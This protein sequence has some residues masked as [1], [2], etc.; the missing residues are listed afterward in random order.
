MKLD[1]SLRI[2]KLFEKPV[3]VI[4]VQIIES[5]KIPEDKFLL[6]DLNY[7][8]KNNYSGY[9]NSIVLLAGYPYDI[10][11]NK[12]RHISVGKI[13]QIYNN[14]EFQHELHTE[15]GSSGSPLC[16]LS[17][18]YVIGIHKKGSKMRKINYGTFIGYFLD[19]LEEG[20]DDMDIDKDYELIE[21]NPFQIL[22]ITEEE[23]KKGIDYKYYMIKIKNDKNVFLAYFILE[24]SNRYDRKGNNFII[25]KNHFYYTIMDEPGNLKNILE[26][27]HLAIYDTDNKGRTLL[28]LSVIGNNYETVKYL[29]KTNI[30][31]NEWDINFKTPVDEAEGEI[32]NLLLSNDGKPYSQV[33]RNTNNP[34]IYQFPIRKI[35]TSIENSNF[36]FI[37]F[38]SKE[39]I[40][41]NLVTKIET[42]KKINKIVAIRL[43]RNNKEDLKNKDLNNYEKVYHGTK[44]CFI[45]SILKNGLKK[46]NKPLIGHISMNITVDN[47][48]DWANA[49]FISPSVFYASSFSDCICSE[50]VI[51]HII[52][53][54]K[55]KNSSYTSHKSTIRNYKFKKGEPKKEIEYRVID[56]EEKV[57]VTSLLLVK[58]EFLEYSQN[59]EDGNIFL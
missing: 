24:N 35:S 3:D 57:I 2:I 27:N 33:F 20:E 12:E 58:N 9:I 16:L 48:S 21:I 56:G 25:E 5:D 22:N 59:Y 32:L 45:E 28:F 1:R 53:E 26:K 42:I 47:I 41:K 10:Q 30:D 36:N 38:I 40:E 11:F 19:K 23:F 51:Y 44:Y 31:I 37:E 17:N 18:Q 29:L 39:L 4:F 55:I 13:I 15:A 49:I 8:N 43:I 46:M 34:K 52:F 14:F 54:G 7:K 50:E 6:P